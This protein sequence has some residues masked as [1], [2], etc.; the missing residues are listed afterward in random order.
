MS[1]YAD[2]W[3]ELA[4]Q[5][6][7]SI[8]AHHDLPTE[9]EDWLR[10]LF[11]RSVS[12]PF[13]PHQRLL[14]EWVW[15][16]GPER[17]RPLVAIWPREGGKSTNA[18]LAI[19]ALLARG[20]RRYGLY[21]SG[22]Q[23]QANAGVAGVG[24][25]LESPAVA[26]YYPSLGMRAVGKFGASK[27]WRRNRLQTMSGAV[28]D[29]IGL[30][31]K[32]IRGLL[33]EGYRP[34]FIILDDVDDLH[35]SPEATKKKILT[36]TQSILPTG[37]SNTAV[38]VV[39]NEIIPTGYVARL[40]RGTELSLADRE[41]IGPIP[42]LRGLET[43]RWEIGE[44]IPRAE[45]EASTVDLTRFS[46]VNRG[47]TIRN[48]ITGGEATWEEGQG[49]EACQDLIDTYGLA[50]FLREQQHEVD[51][52]EGALW[53][54]SMIGRVGAQPDDLI[55][56]VVGVDPSGG[57][58]DIG[59]VAAG[60]DALG[61]IFVL[62]DRTCRGERG[63]A[64]WGWEVIKLYDDL[65]ADLIAAESNYGGDQ[66]EFVIRAAV[67]GAARN[68]VPVKMV[69]STHGKTLRA[70]P[71]VL[72]YE[73]GRVF[74]VGVLPKL[75]SQ[76]TTWVPPLPGTR[77]RQSPD[78]VDALVFACTELLFPEPVTQRVVAQHPRGL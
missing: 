64:H 25:L 75:E 4:D 24:A 44:E 40:G 20:V 32:S 72:A 19:A 27:G 69:P 42:S 35:D 6:D 41:V 30:E 73:E 70:G 76:Q 3:L 26:H 12:K 34:D 61:R 52:V 22:T 49:I 51:E 11:P 45:R 7:P 63:P 78:R 56:I 14:W 47:I 67:D 54:K 48:I 21:V 46:G 15:A 39:Q 71:V 74:H 9:W 38:L 57:G 37:T 55:R 28:L 66:V 18:R 8:A 2:S 62:A 59:I 43:Y 58:D 17:P 77:S 5:I 13:A 33:V 31:A 53:R 65:K 23:E 10:E 1:L 50:A 60:I 29:A 36:I 16:M 68:N